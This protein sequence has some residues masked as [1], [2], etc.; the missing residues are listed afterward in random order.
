MI[1]YSNSEEIYNELVENSDEDWLYGL[2]S[3]AIF[4]E[5]RIEWAK[6]FTTHNDRPPNEQEIQSWYAQQ[7]RSV[8]VKAKGTAEKALQDF[9]AE[10]FDSYIESQTRGIEEGIIVSEIKSINKFWPQF[11]VNVAGGFVSAMIFTALLIIFAVFVLNDASPGSISDHISN[12]LEFSEN[13]KE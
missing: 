3:F 9:T 11:G 2:V 6:H 5:Q 8:L 7:P 4:E 10:A 13:V 12:K 1:K